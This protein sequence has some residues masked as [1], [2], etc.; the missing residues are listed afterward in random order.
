MQRRESTLETVPRRRLFVALVLESPNSLRVEG[1]QQA[2]G[3][4]WPPR[5]PPH[6]TLVPPVNVNE[7]RLSEALAVVR[8]A[9][10]TTVR[11]LQVTIGPPDSFLPRT[12]VLFATVE[13]PGGRVANLARRLA[14]EPLASPS[15][16]PIRRFVPHVTLARKVDRSRV[17]AAKAALAALHLPVRFERVTT[18]EQGDDHRWRPLA[19][20][21]LGRRP[22]IGTGGLALCLD[23][24]RHLD[25]EMAAFLAG[26]GQLGA[27]LGGGFIT[28]RRDEQVVGLAS[29]D[30]V[31]IDPAVDDLDV[32][33]HL[34]AAVRATTPPGAQ[35]D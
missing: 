20:A 34:L 2:C 14:K 19:D 31:V 35:V 21:E 7:E 25:P 28:A 10:A 13:D 16:R 15:S 23:R 22:V 6:I 24:S 4:S 9:A 8:R 29:G 11:P 3:Y 5:V 12:P 17:N 32:R 27:D 18:L 33:R 30:L 1:L 26:N